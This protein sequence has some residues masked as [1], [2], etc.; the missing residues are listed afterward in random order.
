M[1]GDDGA[2]E[3]AGSAMLDAV[4]HGLHA[5]E[6]AGAKRKRATVE[7][8]PREVPA[9]VAV[10]PPAFA[11]PSTAA[12]GAG[13]LVSL[14]GSGADV[15]AE[16]F[17]H[18]VTSMRD[19]SAQGGAC[20]VA[21][22]AGAA[23]TQTAPGPALPD[24]PSVVELT[25]RANFAT[26]ACAGLGLGPPRSAGP[27]AW[28]FE[29]EMVSE[30]VVQVGWC[31]AAFAASSAEGDGVGDHAASWSFDGAR[32]LAWAG[33]ESRPYG[34]QEPWVAGDILGCLLEL[35]PSGAGGETSAR[36]SFSLNGDD[37]GAAHELQLR[38]ET[39]YP[40]LSLEAG[41]VCR[42]N[43]GGRG[44]AY[45]PSR[46]G[47][48]PVLAAVSSEGA[49]LPEALSCGA[50]AGR[51]PAR[52]Q[53]AGVSAAALAPA[54][55]GSGAG[56]PPLPAEGARPGAALARREAEPKPVATAAP[57]PPP[58]RPDLSALPGRTP[59]AAG[60]VAMTSV[61]SFEAAGFTLADLKAELQGRGLKAGGSYAERC[62]RLLAVRGLAAAEVPLK[63]RGEGFPG[64]LLLQ[65]AK[66]QQH[67]D[68][69]SA[70]GGEE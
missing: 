65:G 38:A 15:D 10:N 6:A 8:T 64:P 17:S 68:E 5:A 70:R 59:A 44:F 30:G 16:Y 46:S 21:P 53:E 60:A 63:L 34:R 42:W 50:Y 13:W 31:T 55:A 54:A 18:E 35:S 24:V 26:V 49:A 29:V 32:C 23:A 1:Y 66:E 47:V 7:Q 33:G 28:Y 51:A 14:S 67:V 48:A 69:A 3:G 45:A 2:E 41:E 36:L 11:F 56:A 9:P 40:A 25:G 4:L 22:T 19:D 20:G 39:L 62:E 27:S 52:Q 43:L 61:R 57:A 37:L 58:P 12:G